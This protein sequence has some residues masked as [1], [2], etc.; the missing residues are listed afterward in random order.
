MLSTVLYKMVSAVN[1]IILR[2]I[3]LCWL[4][5]RSTGEQDGSSRAEL[6][7]C[8]EDYK[9]GYYYF[10]VIPVKKIEQIYGTSQFNKTGATNKSLL[11]AL[12]I[13]FQASKTHPV[14]KLA[15]M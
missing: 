9:N 10:C 6:L 14:F 1:G 7:S 13:K 15:I 8:L 5:V 11:L 3:F 2:P 4:L 12:D